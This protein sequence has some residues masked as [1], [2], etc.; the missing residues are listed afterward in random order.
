[1]I[2]FKLHFGAYFR[3]S[4]RFKTC[5]VQHEEITMKIWNTIFTLKFIDVLSLSLTLGLSVSVCLSVC[6]SISLSLVPNWNLGTRVS[7]VTISGT[8][9]QNAHLLRTIASSWKRDKQRSYSLGSGKFDKKS[10]WHLKL[11]LLKHD[12]KINKK[13]IKR[14]DF[15][16]N[17]CWD[18]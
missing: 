1:M 3:L 14:K 17:I 10:T 5:F 9:V 13:K 4:S 16:Q 11:N 7:W 2:S 8:D 18:C 6:L 15:G 12:K